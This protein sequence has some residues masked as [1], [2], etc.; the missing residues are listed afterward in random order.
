VLRFK[1]FAGSGPDLERQVNSWLEEFEPDVTQMA[2]TFHDGIVI[3]SFLFQESFR[4][5]ELR[6]ASEH[7]VSRATTPAV[8]PHMN[9]DEPITVPE[10][11]GGLSTGRTSAVS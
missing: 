10:E 6:L 11:P 9:P 2:Q 1:Q 7:G 4:G 8:P 3:M 5:Q